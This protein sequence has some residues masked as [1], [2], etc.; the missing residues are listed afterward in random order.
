MRK[1]TKSEMGKVSGGEGVAVAI[2]CD[3]YYASD[4]SSM[5][6]PSVTDLSGITVTGVATNPQGTAGTLSWS[7]PGGQ[8]FSITCPAGTYPI[9]IGANT[10]AEAS[11]NLV[12]KVLNLVGIKVAGSFSGAS[13]VPY[14]GGP[15]S[16]SGIHE[17]EIARGHTLGRVA[18]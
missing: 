16:G 15:G 5:T 1:L 14:S 12:T 6:F 11:G 13:C 9:Q 7:A 4:E 17:P 3:V 10:N 18:A 2:G 8:N